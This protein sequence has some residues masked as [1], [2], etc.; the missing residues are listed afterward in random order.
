MGSMNDIANGTAFPSIPAQNT[1]G[2]L[3]LNNRP[4]FFGCN[5]SNTS[6]T[7]PLIVY[8][9]N[10]PYTY[11]SN[12]STFQLEYTKEQQYAIPTGLPAS[13]VPFFSAHLKGHRLRFHRSAKIASRSTAGTAGLTTASQHNHTILSMFL[14]IKLSMLRALL[15]VC[16]RQTRLHWARLHFSHICSCNL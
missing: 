4:T 14:R 13:A 8:L 9:P 15:V 12:V 5:S 6:S 1:F 16:W 3:G 11:H 10:S 7:T 2:N